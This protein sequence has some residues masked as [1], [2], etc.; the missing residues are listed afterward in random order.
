MKSSGAKTAKCDHQKNYMHASNFRLQYLV[1]KNQT[2]SIQNLHYFIITPVKTLAFF[3]QNNSHSFANIA[4]HFLTPLHKI[5]GQ[6]H[7]VAFANEH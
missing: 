2:I 7:L 3:T 6:M 4:K 1:F 5:T